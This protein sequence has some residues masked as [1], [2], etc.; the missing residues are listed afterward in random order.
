MSVVD[1]HIDAE[2]EDIR[3]VI[4][5]LPTVDL[6]VTTLPNVQLIAAGNV[7]PPGPPGPEGQWTALTQSEYDA[8]TP[9]DPDTLYVI[10]Q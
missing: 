5:P 8:L 7:G 1:L 9:P 10:I 3:V 4:D 2:K 6:T